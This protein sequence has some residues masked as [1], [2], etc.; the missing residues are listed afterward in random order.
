MTPR[1][2]LTNFRNELATLCE[3]YDIEL[4]TECGCRIAANIGDDPMIA[5][6]FCSNATTNEIRNAEIQ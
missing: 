5:I 1:E 2:R 6:D 3:M 4:S